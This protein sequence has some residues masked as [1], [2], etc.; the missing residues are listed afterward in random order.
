MANYYLAITLL[1]IATLIGAFM[2]GGGMTGMS[3]SIN[4]VGVKKLCI[5]SS[6]CTPQEACCLFSGKASGVC[7]VAS[8]CEQISAL[9]KAEFDLSTQV[10]PGQDAALLPAD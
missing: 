4:D 3:I 9:T 5:D 1:I 6:D 2:I 8:N 10:A 7:D